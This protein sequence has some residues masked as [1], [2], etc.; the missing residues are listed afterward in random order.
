MIEILVGLVIIVF[1]FFLLDSFGDAIIAIIGL[2]V[3]CFIAYCIGKVV[4]Q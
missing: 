1:V 2:S 3:L 4:L